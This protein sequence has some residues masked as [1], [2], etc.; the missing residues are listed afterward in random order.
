[1]DV[2]IKDNPR[3]HKSLYLGQ[4]HCRPVIHTF[5]QDDATHVFAFSLCHLPISAVLGLK[6]IV[7]VFDGYSLESV[8][9]AS[10]RKPHVLRKSP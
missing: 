1:M 6:T 3:L 4:Y 9:T 7:L 5:P 2:L 10:M 8:W